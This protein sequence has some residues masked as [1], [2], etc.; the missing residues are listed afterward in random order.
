MTIHVNFGFK[1]YS[2]KELVILSAFSKKE[3]KEEKEELVI[4]HWKKN[5]SE[6]FHKIISSKN[7]V[8]KAG[9]HFIF[10]LDDGR[11]ILALGLGEKKKYNAEVLRRKIA[12]I[13]KI[14]KN[15][16]TDI[17]IDVDSFLFR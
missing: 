6:A 8:G 10:H 14:L 5:Y 2:S 16:S 15:N 12:S 17:S 13:Y 1:D 7:F 11:T 4:P 3:K 9:E